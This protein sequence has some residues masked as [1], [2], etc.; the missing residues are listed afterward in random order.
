MLLTL[1]NQGYTVTLE[2][3][4]AELKSYKSEAGKEFVWNSDPK[5]WPLITASFSFHRQS[6]EWKDDNKRTGIRDSQT[7]FCEGY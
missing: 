6:E 2:T 3:V 4:G 5:F 7:W 1:K